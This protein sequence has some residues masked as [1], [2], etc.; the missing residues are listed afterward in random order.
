MTRQ[1]LAGRRIGELNDKIVAWSDHITAKQ[2]G[3]N[4]QLQ[5]DEACTKLARVYPKL[6]L[7]DALDLSQEQHLPLRKFKEHY[8]SGIVG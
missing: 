5:A 3:V 7:D 4:G 2:R 6:R 1:C 8:E